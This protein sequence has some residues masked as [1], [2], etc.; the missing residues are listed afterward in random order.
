MKIN[1]HITHN[2]MIITHEDKL[3]N[4]TQPHDSYS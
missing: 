2:L 4:H 1:K 3:T